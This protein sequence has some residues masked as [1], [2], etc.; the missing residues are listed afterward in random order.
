M[1]G[2]EDKNQQPGRDPPQPFLL[3]QL[4]GEAMAARLFSTPRNP[5]RRRAPPP[6]ARGLP[7]TATAQRHHHHHPLP[8]G[9]PA[10]LY[11]GAAV[12]RHARARLTE[13]HSRHRVDP[14]PYLQGHPVLSSTDTLPRYEPRGGEPAPV[15]PGGSPGAAAASSGPRASEAAGGGG[16]GREGG[17]GLAGRRVGTG[18]SAVTSHSGPPPS[19]HSVE[20]GQDA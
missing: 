11:R 1:C 19:Y 13:Q 5:N 10:G 8:T 14:G 2:K 3:S 20:S 6:A 12:S 9:A 17:G 16:G 15:P 7:G 4:D 18:W